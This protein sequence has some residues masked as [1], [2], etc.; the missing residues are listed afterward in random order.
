LRRICDRLI[1]VI[2]VVGA[3]G[4]S[5]R[6]GH[7]SQFVRAVSV[8]GSARFFSPAFSGSNHKGHRRF[9]FLL[10]IEIGNA[11]QSGYQRDARAGSI[12][13]SIPVSSGETGFCAVS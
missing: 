5:A 7:P 6:L 11:V 13:H 4:A 2:V 8:T 3:G 12:T 1:V 10:Q 9:E